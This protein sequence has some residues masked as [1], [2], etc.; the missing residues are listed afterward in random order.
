MLKL[1]EMETSVVPQVYDDM[2]F[3]YKRFNLRD[4]EEK[5]YSNNSNSAVDVISSS[6]YFVAHKKILLK[7]NLVIADDL[8]VYSVTKD[9]CRFAKCYLT[10]K[11]SLVIGCFHEAVLQ[12][13]DVSNQLVQFK[14][15]VLDCQFYW[16]KTFLNTV[17]QY[18][19]GRRAHH[20][21]LTDKEN[22]QSIV[23]DVLLHVKA[24]EQMRSLSN[25]LQPTEVSN[26]QLE[27]CK[28]LKSA[29]QLLAKL[30]GGRAFLTGNIVEMMMVFEYFKDIYFN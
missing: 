28:E 10:E 8:T 26:C 30:H 2:D 29:N 27:A 9:S 20:G 25:E 1:A 19:Q 11:Y 6:R 17:H 16:T 13:E 24:A 23:S 15:N 22:V 14:N 21:V 7:D 18:L 5:I 4:I 12:Q 3:D